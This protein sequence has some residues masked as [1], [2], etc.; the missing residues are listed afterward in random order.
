MHRAKPRT[1]VTKNSIYL[2][3]AGMHLQIDSFGSFSSISGSILYMRV[4]PYFT[5]PLI[6]VAAFV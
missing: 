6:R 2:S 5:I 1:K 3:H 4:W